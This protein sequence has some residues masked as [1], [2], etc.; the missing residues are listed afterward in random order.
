VG[1][2]SKQIFVNEA[3]RCIFRGAQSYS[4]FRHGINTG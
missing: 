1:A 4:T 2:E 3:N